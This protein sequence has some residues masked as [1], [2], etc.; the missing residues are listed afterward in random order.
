IWAHPMARGPK[1]PL[2]GLA[3]LCGISYRFQ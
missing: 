1:V 3:T 2:F